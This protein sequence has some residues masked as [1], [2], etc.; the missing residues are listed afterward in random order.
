MAENAE[1]N[2]PIID[3]M[4]RQVVMDTTEL[5]DA[6]VKDKPSY[7]IGL[8]ETEFKQNVLP[9]IVGRAQ[10]PNG[11][12]SAF[13]GY[14][15]TRAGSET[16]PIPV[17]GVDGSVLFEMPPLLNTASVRSGDFKAKITLG[18]TA[19]EAKLRSGRLPIE[20][21]ALMNSILNAPSSPLKVVEE[22][23]INE[24]METFFKMLEERYGEEGRR[25]DKTTSNREVLSTS[26]DD[27]DLL[28]D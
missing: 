11:K 27:D 8:S 1:L 22:E 26:G 10:I 16:N 20:G 4:L 5:F 3:M 12:Q 17:Y 14:L 9:F 23:A 13:I 15:A 19:Q 6:F 18:N 2:N 25:V 28:L 7:V 24:T 21:R